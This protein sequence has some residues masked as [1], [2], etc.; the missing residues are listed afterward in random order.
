MKEKKYSISEASRLLEVENHVLRYWEDELE[1]KIPRNEL[2]HR[3]YREQEIQLLYC[4]KELKNK[5]FQLKAVK[6]VLP[7]LEEK[8]MIDVHKL[9]VTQ[10]EL[11]NMEAMQEEQKRREREEQDAEIESGLAEQYAEEETVG[12]NKVVSLRKNEDSKKVHSFPVRQEPVSI[13]SNE[14]KM[15]EFENIMGRIIGRAL[16]DQAQ[17][18][19]DAMSERICNRVVREID[20]AILDQEERTEAYFKKLD[21]AIRTH[22]RARQEIAVARDEGGRKKSR[23]FQKNKRKI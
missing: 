19:S 10:V 13:R 12:E 7:D 22:Q 15:Q 14:E 21:E 4:I 8:Q 17:D 1:L 11:E 2:G 3:Y 20:D 16:H 6:E 23:F 9:L 18:I 5:G